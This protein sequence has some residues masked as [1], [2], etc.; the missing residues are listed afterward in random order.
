[1]SAAAAATTQEGHSPGS[2]A[3][4]GLLWVAMLLLGGLFV[5]DA[6][7]ALETEPDECYAYAY[8]GGPGGYGCNPL[9]GDAYFEVD[10]TDDLVDR[11][12]VHIDGFLFEANRSFGIV[13]CS[14]VAFSLPDTPSGVD[15]CD[16]STV[17]FGSTDGTGSLSTDLR[18]R[19][20]I[21]TP[22]AGEVDCAEPDAACVIAGGVLGADGMSTTEAAYASITFDPDAPPVPPPT[23]TIDVVE[24]GADTATLLVD[25]TNA[26]DLSI[27]VQLQ[28][29][30]DGLYGS[31]Y[32]YVSFYQESPPC[33]DGPT[34]FEVTL[35]PGSRRIGRGDV[36]YYV[37]GYTSD[38][39]ESVSTIEEGEFRV[40]R[41]PVP[42]YID[43]NEP[44]SDLRIEVL[45]ITGYGRSQ[46]VRVALTC[47]RPITADDPPEYASLA[48]QVTQWAGLDSIYGYGDIEITECD[49]RT[50]MSVPLRAANGRLHTGNAQLHVSANVQAYDGDI[51]EYYYD[52]AGAAEKI[53]LRG[54]LWAPLQDVDRN[55][56]SRITFDTVTRAG[57]RGTV[58]CEEP[59]TVD[60]QLSAQQYDRRVIRDTYAYLYEECDGT[61]EF[62]V[63]WDRPLSWG[64]AG[65]SA[66]A[67]GYTID[68]DWEPPTYPTVTYPQL[69][70]TTTTTTAGPPAAMF[71]DD[72]TL[73]VARSIDAGAVADGYITYA[74]FDQQGALVWVRR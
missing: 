35:E 17:A 22:D 68:D 9:L 10:R 5:V 67:N 56:D 69:T 28:Q 60:L 71:D 72:V 59:V 18:V 6:I 2:K 52:Q 46:K 74:W 34:E 57:I 8:G 48:V 23:L 39:F 26:V 63:E 12:I 70:T 32:G 66:Y 15:A 40:R 30:I 62:D 24:I 27:D 61:L 16:L 43:A 41:T 11:Q 53:R 54:W 33:S 65:V 4:V 51:G 73:P 50:V 37:F 44:G 38:G 1:M 7:G 45:G 55:P 49:G 21:T 29:E 36:T 58:E 25:C 19:R 13:Q 31:A 3:V 42:T 47:D 64:I 20:I 14:G